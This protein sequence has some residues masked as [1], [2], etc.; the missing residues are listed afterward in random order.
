MEN[1][2]EILQKLAEQDKKIDAVYQSVEKTRKYFLLTLI[3]SV[4]VIILPLIGILFMMPNFLKI[5]TGNNLG[6]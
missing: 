1:E 3:I 4:A 5:M 6:L 2:N